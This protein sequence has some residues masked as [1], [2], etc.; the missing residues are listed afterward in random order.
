MSRLFAPIVRTWSRYAGAVP[1]TNGLAVLRSV[2]PAATPGT[3]K[4]VG[5]N[6]TAAVCGAPWFGSHTMFALWL[7]YEGDVPETG[8]AMG[9]PVLRYKIPLMVH[10]PKTASAAPLRLAA[11]PLPT[12]RS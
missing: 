7:K 10:P 9:T 2:L 11:R 12:G 3:V 4:H 5:L 1:G 6:Q 8:D